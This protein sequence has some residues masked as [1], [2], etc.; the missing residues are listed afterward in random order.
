MEKTKPRGILMRLTSI[1]KKQEIFNKKKNLKDSGNIVLS[2]KGSSYIHDDNENDIIKLDMLLSTKQ[3]QEVKYQLLTMSLRSTNRLLIEGGCIQFI[4]FPFRSAVTPSAFLCSPTKRVTLTECKRCLLTLCPNCTQTTAIS[5]P[6]AKMAA[7][8]DTELHRFAQDDVILS[9]ATNRIWSQFNSISTFQIDAYKLSKK[10]IIL[11]LKLFGST[12]L[13][14]Q[15]FTKTLNAEEKVVHPSFGR[16]LRGFQ[17]AKAMVHPLH[18]SSPRNCT[19]SS[20]SLPG[21]N[22]P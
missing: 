14:R 20:S 9:P 11:N 2:P 1:H 7:T 17:S 13:P 5:T 6:R 16:C 8:A 3:V 21:K 12:K 15:L 4:P 22:N 10:Y 19:F 18:R